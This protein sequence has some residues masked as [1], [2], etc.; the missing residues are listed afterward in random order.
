MTTAPT[1][2][3][4]RWLRGQDLNLRPSGY[5]PDELPT[6]PP[7]A[8]FTPA[9]ALATTTELQK[10]GAG[11]E[12]RTLDLYLGKVSLYQLSYS[13]VKP[14]SSTWARTRDLR[15]NSPALYQLSY[16]G[17]NLLVPMGR[18]ELPTSPLPREC[19]TTELHGQSQALYSAV[20]PIQPH[21]LL[22]RKSPTRTGLSKSFVLLVPLAGVELATFA[23]R[24]RCST[25]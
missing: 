17:I 5:E 19:S 25:N 1:R 18:I 15:I 10:T 6:A 14:G 12:S 2:S 21:L 13:R 8:R 22:H 24:M 23:L 4:K 9:S 11:E 20:K 7:R 3:E 16:R